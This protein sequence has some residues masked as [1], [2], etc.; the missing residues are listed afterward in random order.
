MASRE[1]YTE[2]QARVLA[3]P[4]CLETDTLLDR[5]CDCYCWI[6]C[7]SRRRGDYRPVDAVTD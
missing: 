6:D 5:L 7:D 2:L 4:S 3:A 1:G